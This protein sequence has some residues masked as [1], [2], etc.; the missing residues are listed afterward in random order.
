VPLW[1]ARPP[2]TAKRGRQRGHR[3]VAVSTHKYKWLYLYGFVR[4]ATGAVERWLANCVNVPLFQSA[5]DG[6]AAAIGAG[7]EMTVILVLD[8]AGRHVSKRLRIPDRI[9][10]F[11]S[12][13]QLADARLIGDAQLS[14][15]TPA[16]IKA[17]TNFPW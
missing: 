8:G 9:R 10:P 14:P 6:L 16:V 4:S 2:S 3:P 15:T 13:D 5:L 7:P 12:L 17:N 11:A 1:A